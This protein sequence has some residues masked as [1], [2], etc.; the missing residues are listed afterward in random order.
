M[1]SP[2]KTLLLKVIVI[3]VACFAGIDLYGQGSVG[4]GTNDPN[5]NAVLE[6][7]TTG[8]Q[9]L[10]LPRMST[11]QRTATSL[12]SVLTTADNGL[13]VFD[14]DEGRIYFWFNGSWVTSSIQLTAG[15]G[16]DLIGNAITNTGDLNP[17]DDVLQGDSPVGGDITGDFAGGLSISSLQGNPVNAA[18]PTTG[19]VLKWNGSEWI[20]ADDD[21]QVLVAGAGVDIVGGAIINT[22]D[23]DGTD[24]LTNASIAGGDITGDFANT[25]IINLQGNPVNALSP[26]TGDVLKWDGAEW[27]PS[28]D[29]SQTLTNGAGIVITGNSI[30]NTGDL[31]PGDDV[32]RGDS[33][34]GGDIGGSYDAGLSVSS[35]QGNT[36]NALTP[37]TGDV[38]K[39]NGTA[40]VPSVDDSQ[41]L[42][43]GAGIVITGNS[44]INTGDLDPSDDVLRG[45]AP[46]GG[47]VSGSF[48]AGLTINPDAV[49]TTALAD[50][51]VTD[52]KI[53]DLALSK[54]KQGGAT[55]GDLL[56]WNNTSGNWEPFTLDAAAENQTLSDVLA[57]GA[58]AGNFQITNVDDLLLNSG[59]T[60][61]TEAT[62]QASLQL[63][64]GVG[65]GNSDLGNLSHPLL[66]DNQSILEAIVQLGDSIDV[67]QTSAFNTTGEV[68]RGDGTGLTG[69]GIFSDGVNVG[70][71]TSTPTTALQVEDR[72]HLYQFTSQEGGLSTI[73]SNNFFTTSPTEFERTVDGQG[74]F[75]LMSDSSGIEFYQVYGGTAG[76]VASEDIERIFRAD[77]GRFSIEGVL[78]MDFGSLSLEGEQDYRIDLQGNSLGDG[79]DLQIYAGAGDTRG[80]DIVLSPG[81]LFSTGTIG[82][83]VS[84]GD[85]RL[86]DRT[87]L[88][89]SIIFDGQLGNRVQIFAPSSTG[90]GYSLTLPDFSGNVGDFLTY[91]A[92]G[93][94]DWSNPVLTTSGAVP[95]GNGTGQVSSNIFSSSSNIGIGIT[96][97]TEQLEV[98]GN[99]EIP[100]ASDY[101]YASAKT[102]EQAYHP[103]EFRHFKF[104]GSTAE[105]VVFNAVNLYTYYEGSSGS[106]Q[107]SGVPVKLPDGA[108]VT[109]VDAWVLDNDGTSTSH[110]VRVRL[111]RS[112]TGV[113]TSS[114]T[115]A[116]LETDGI[117]ANPTVEQLTQTSI[118]NRTIDNANYSYR[119][120]FT[121]IVSSTSDLQL[122]GAK[123][124]YTVSKVD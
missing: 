28:V 118:F 90:P 106:Q 14:T 107:T 122:H 29:D 9:G 87:G 98:A 27:V 31:D 113:A 61:E 17:D 58:D 99:V 16:I 100:A 54:L 86:A 93:I 110:F 69:S 77:S 5:P 32:L 37:A 40:W 64:T 30:I 22:G 109:Q 76:T 4:I 82:E 19:Q 88:G 33:P 46:T 117:T 56:N 78:D 36:L 101:Q 72:T 102:K 24:D 11:V 97:P 103:T 45:D 115:M 65:V 119:L 55:D 62:N 114:E 104:P 26:A 66:L 120:I 108:Q 60:V 49:T 95:V 81:G 57:K 84:D 63:L 74:S 67:I 34:V 91:G 73:L 50:G 59:T 68:P 15:D 70:I 35:L 38:L 71:G 41:T 92:G 85:L 1:K 21:G 51:A 48:D 13:T 112:P 20:T 10:L 75:L 8:D 111:V 96:N 105:L 7:A 18:T 94:L 123:I 124:T 42:T 23:I 53:S 12:T 89:G 25:S 47:D 116:T 79:Y 43:D 2:T 52:V 44:I 3:V 83:V 121:S 80:G 6:L 39:W